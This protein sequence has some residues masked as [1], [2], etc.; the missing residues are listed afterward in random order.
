VVSLLSTSEGGFAPSPILFEKQQSSF[1]LVTPQ[2]LE[3]K[4]LPFV[5]ANLIGIVV[6]LLL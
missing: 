2:I 4:N 5:G 1:V 3:K 6:L